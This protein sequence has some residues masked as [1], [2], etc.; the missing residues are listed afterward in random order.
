MK[1]IAREAGVSVMT[2]SK[3]MRDTPDISAST[4]ARIRRLADDMGYGDFE[5]I[6]GATETPNLN[7]MADQGVFFSNFY[8]GIFMDSSPFLGSCTIPFRRIR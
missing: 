1:D 7:R 5:R 6:G 8:A 2:V 4:K 3:V